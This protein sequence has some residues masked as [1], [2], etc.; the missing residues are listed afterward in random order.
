MSLR[1]IGSREFVFSAVLFCFLSLLSAEAQDVDV[2]GNLTMH[3]STD[4]TVGN[5]L[6]EGVPFLHNFGTNNTFLGSGAGNFTMTGIDN[7]ASGAGAL[8]SNTTGSNNTASGDQALFSN[9]SGNNNTAIGRFALFSNTT[10]SNNSASGAASL[11]LNTTGDAN[12][13][14]GIG[15]LEGNTTGNSNTASGFLA[16][17]NNSTGNFNT[18]TGPGALEGNTTGNSNTAS[19]FLA[20][21]NNSTG[22]FNTAVGAHAL[23]YTTGSYNTAYGYQALTSNTTGS[24]NTA[25]GYRADVF[26]NNLTNAT[27]IGFGAVVNASNKIRLGN[28][29][30]TVIE[31]QVPYTY[32]SD[33]NE[34]EN[35]RAVDADEVL[36]KL[37]GLS[38]TSWNYRGQDAK[39]FR[40][41]GPVAQDFFAAFGHD[42][43]GS[44]GTPTTITSGDLDGILMIAVQALEKH[45]VEQEKEIAELKARLEVLERGVGGHALT[46][47]Q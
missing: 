37:R 44:I 12:T 30:V 43:V 4:V 27:A 9:T 1:K 29:Q 8:G 25:I 7:T 2:P 19:G 39:Q 24:Y 36:T 46:A 33:R 13:A 16:L 35:F 6:K 45:T 20:L 10:G 42:A 23:F 21:V 5:I 34:K 38:V 41:Y 47:A 15:A 17:V 26:Q 14:T 11:Y 40:H 22:N 28:D 31:G 3:D 18:A 32:T